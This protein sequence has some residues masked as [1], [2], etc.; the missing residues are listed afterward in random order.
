[1]VQ[2]LRLRT[3]NARGTGLIPGQ[4]TKIPHAVWCGQKYI[5]KKKLK[6]EKQLAAAKSQLPLQILFKLCSLP[7]SSPFL[8]A[9]Q[10]SYCPH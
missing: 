2:W 6:I 7:Q 4:G 5:Y 8:I 10:S 1:M 9:S 3:S